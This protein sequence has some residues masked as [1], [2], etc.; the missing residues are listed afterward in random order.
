MFG[1]EDDWSEQEKSR[2]IGDGDAFGKGDTTEEIIDNGPEVDNNNDQ[3]LG[4]GDLENQRDVD[5]KV[6]GEDD[7]DDN[8][9]GEEYIN[10][11]EEEVDMM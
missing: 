10:N 1:N 11:I 4:D 2:M 6:E 7:E 5:D 3:I 9:E 8:G